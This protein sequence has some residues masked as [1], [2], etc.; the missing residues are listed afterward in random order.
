MRIGLALGFLLAAALAVEIVSDLGHRDLEDLKRTKVKFKIVFPS[1]HPV[2]I[3]RAQGGGDL[4]QPFLTAVAR[5]F[6]FPGL[7]VAVMFFLRLGLMGNSLSLYERV[8][9][10]K[11]RSR[12][13]SAL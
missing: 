2:R 1:P 7:S 10:G 5:V 13:A 11:C 9:A 4:Y 3:A 12:A 8:F 6:L